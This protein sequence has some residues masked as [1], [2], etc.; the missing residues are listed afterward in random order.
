[1]EGSRGEKRLAAQ[2][3]SSSCN[4]RW[5][6]LKAGELG[7]V[8]VS[9]LRPVSSSPHLW[10][11]GTPS[12]SRLTFYPL[13]RLPFPHLFLFWWLPSCSR[14]KIFPLPTP[15]DYQNTSVKGHLPLLKNTPLLSYEKRHLG[16]GFI[17]NCS[18]FLPE[19]LSK[20]FVL[21]CEMS[22]M[23]MWKLF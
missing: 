21:Q 4:K 2:Q 3:V 7:S 19:M 12:P 22:R 13:S 14:S 8:S 11:C 9:T 20:C 5:Y 16:Y 18:Y 15:R 1:M 10:T 6:G 17:W 23:R